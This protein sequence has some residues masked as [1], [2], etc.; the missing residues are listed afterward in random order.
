MEGR[1][2]SLPSEPPED[3]EEI[4]RDVIVVG[5][6]AGGVEA[7][8]G[9]MRGLPPELPASMFVVLHL[10][11]SGTSVLP[12]ILGRAGALEAA[13]AMDQEPIERGRV[14][15]APPD[16]HLL[17]ANGVVRVTRGPRENGHRPAIDP[18]FRSAARNYGARVIGVIL[19]GA[20]DDG[21]AGLRVIKSQGGTT[22]AQD[23]SEALYPGMPTSALA[24]EAVDHVARV[25]EMAA[26]ICDLVEAPLAVSELPPP[27]AEAPS[28]LDLHMPSLAE[29]DPSGLTCPDCGGALWERREGPVVNFVCR[30][31]HAFSPDSLATQQSR[32]LEA[33]LWSALRSLEERADLLRRL[34]RRSSSARS[35]ERFEQQAQAADEH[36]RLVRDAI[37]RLGNR[38]DEL[39]LQ[40]EAAS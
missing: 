18:L 1:I 27:P 7:L 20:L 31:G 29:G 13:S 39:D 6:S 14:Y 12:H 23:P 4:Y 22:I 15:V 34:S 30:T 35:A 28:E 3:S 2:T 16:R 26:L 17:M 37:L 25:D 10:M 33:A 24:A 32:S 8:G 9:L 11:P 38:P 21:V 5:A 36:G 40:D 19:S